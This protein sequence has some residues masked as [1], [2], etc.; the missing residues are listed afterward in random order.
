MKRFLLAVL[1]VLMIGGFLRAHAQDASSAPVTHAVVSVG[2]GCTGFVIR[3]TLVATASHCVGQPDGRARVTLVV[4]GQ[5]REVDG[6][7]VWDSVFQDFPGN[8]GVIDP[9]LDFALILLPVAHERVVSFDLRVP[10]PGTPLETWGTAGGIFHWPA[11]LH[12]VGLFWHVK[13]GD[14]LVTRGDTY[15]GA[16]GSSIFLNG[17][18]VGIITHGI[19]DASPLPIIMGAPSYRLV[20]GV[21]DYDRYGAM[22]FCSQTQPD[23][24]V[25]RIICRGDVRA[26]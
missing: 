25:L 20:R 3:P 16:S 6:R 15:P 26:S 4:G 11:T 7:V 5:R 21:E 14:V 22:R 1:V 24:R 19:I 17:R 13:I 8:T 12:L 9:A 2:D 18:V 23:G 10:S